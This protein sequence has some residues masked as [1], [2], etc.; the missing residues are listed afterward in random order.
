MSVPIF[1]DVDGEVLSSEMEPVGAF[2]CERCDY[3]GRRVTAHERRSDALLQDIAN[4]QRDARSHLRKITALEVELE[5]QKVD[6]PDWSTAKTI[7]TRWVE[8]SG[9]NPKTTKFGDKRAKAVLAALKKYDADFVLVAVEA[10][11]R[12]ANNNAREVERLALIAAMEEAVRILGGDDLPD[13]DPVAHLR[14]YYSERR[15]DPLVYDDLELILRNE[16][17]VERFHSIGVRL[18]LAGRV[19]GGGSPC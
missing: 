6:D 1:D 3:L 12:A 14:A 10:G 17:N 7:F 11:V 9:R 4:L 18:G 2:G 5:K 16:V 19:N 15:G 8:W 13:G